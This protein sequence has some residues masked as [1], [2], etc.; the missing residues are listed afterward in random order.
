M[1]SVNCWD[2]SAEVAPDRLAACDQSLMC[3]RLGCIGPTHVSESQ[4]AC[5]SKNLFIGIQPLKKRHAVKVCVI[6]KQLDL[7]DVLLVFCKLK[8]KLPDI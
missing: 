2:L 6:L 7:V 1:G 3:F 8:Q 5:I 4:G